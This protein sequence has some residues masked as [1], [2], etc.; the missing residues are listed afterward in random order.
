M[1]MIGFDADGVIVNSRRRAWQ[2]VEDII[3]CFGTRVAIRSQEQLD[4]QFGPKGL[5]RLV[6]PGH[7]PTL[8]QVH[9]LVMRHAA[10]AIS[11][12][13][14]I[15]PV[16]EALPGRKLLITA[17]LGDG[18][19]RCLGRH[20]RHFEA[21]VGFEQ[22]RKPD[23][24]ARHAS[25]LAVY[26]TDTAADIIDCRALGVPVIGCRWGYDS[27]AALE[28]ARPDVIAERPADLL[29]LIGALSGDLSHA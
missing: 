8:R 4:A 5:A 29:D 22:G 1:M 7:E 14:E 19:A 27:L 21:I 26:V 9:R 10:G 12:F 13:D 23:L 6:G 20:A 25:R 3:A 15:I 28:R 11:L 2:A 24:L 18:I 16:I 17:A